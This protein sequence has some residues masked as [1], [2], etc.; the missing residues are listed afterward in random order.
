MMPPAKTKKFAI[1]I[2]VNEQWCKACDICVAFCP[3]DCLEVQGLSVVV[4]DADAC[5]GCMMCE[6][7][8]PDFAIK[9]HKERLEGAGADEDAGED[10]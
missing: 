10:A 3:H 8:C 2:D 5:T 6:L 1:S 4:V 9:V 7:I